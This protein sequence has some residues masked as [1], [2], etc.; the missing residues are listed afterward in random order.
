MFKKSILIILA[1]LILLAASCSAA[2]EAN[3]DDTLDIT[4]SPAVITPEQVS[5]PT[6]QTTVNTAENKPEAKYIFYF[7]GDGMG[8]GHTEL[9]EEFLKYA[10]DDNNALLS[11]NTLNVNTTVATNSANAEVT[12]SA[13]A[14]TALATGVKTNNA[15]VGLSPEG[16]VLTTLLEAV[17]AKGYS[18]GIITTAR[19]THATPACFYAHNSHRENEDEIATELLDSNIDFIAGGGLCYFLPAEIP[20]NFQNLPHDIREIDVYS[21]RTDDVNLIN[22]FADKGYEMFIGPDGATEFFDF[23]PKAGDKVFATFTYNNFPYEIDRVG[24]N[25]QFPSLSDLTRQATRLLSTDEEGF[26]LMVEGGRIDHASHNNDALGVIYDTLAFDNAVAVALDFYAAHPDE[27]IIIV[28]ADHETGGLELQSDANYKEAFNSVEGVY[29]S[30]EDELAPLY[31]STDNKEDYLNKLNALGLKLTEN[32]LLELATIYDES[33]LI[34]Y[35]ENELKTATSL[36]LNRILNTRLGVSWTTYDHTADVVTLGVTGV[37][38][39][40]FSSAKENIDNA[41]ILADILQ[42][43]TGR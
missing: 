39:Q 13:A 9:S 40:H 16:E 14:A 20:E 15:M 23:D 28:T 11:L 17:Q 1:I 22:K 8:K 37:F 19:I 26:F 38:E 31:Y 29:A 27:T 41:N 32:E 3:V 34:Y 7:I 42:V 6:P 25:T 5:T 30:Y 10:L 21:Q 18:T 35:S 24:G 4:P 2:Q 12:D 43:D 36:A 33:A